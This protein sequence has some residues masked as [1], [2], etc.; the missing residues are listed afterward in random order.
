MFLETGDSAKSQG[1]TPIIVDTNGNG[2]RDDGDTR[3]K[4]AFYGIMPSPVDDSGWGQAMGKGFGRVDQPGYVIRLIPRAHPAE[5]ARS[6]VFV[7]PQGAWGPR[8][9]DM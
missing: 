1:W 7:P 5:T 8:G 6:E 9:H 2:R 4:A 3:L